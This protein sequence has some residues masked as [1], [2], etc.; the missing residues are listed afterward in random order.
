M[1]PEGTAKTD[2]GDAAQD[3]PKPASSAAPKE[4][5]ADRLKEVTEQIS[6]WSARLGGVKRSCLAVGRPLVVVG[7]LLVILARG[8]DA[9]G[10]RGVAGARMGARIAKSDF[11]DAWGRKEEAIQKDVRQLGAIAEPTEDQK[12]RLEARRKDLEK[13]R[14]DRQKEESDLQAGRW[15]RLDIA[16][17][18]ADAWQQIKGPSRER[19]FVFGTLLL[20]FGLLSVAMS[21][22]GAER[23]VALVILSIVILS[24]YNAVIALGRM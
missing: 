1:A 6:K 11:N 23:W 2:S 12:A 9:V 13:V 4:P 3:A 5:A 15:R 10:R 20:V 14:A 24:F 22:Q 18:D 19:W 16:A 17:R 8:C 21:G 7:L